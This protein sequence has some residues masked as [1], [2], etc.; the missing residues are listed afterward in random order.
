MF[1]PLFPFYPSPLR[2]SFYFYT[3][4][5]LFQFNADGATDMVYIASTSRIVYVALN[6][7]GGTLDAPSLILFS[8]S[9]AK[10]IAIEDIDAD[11]TMDLVMRVDNEIFF[12]TNDGTGAFTYAILTVDALDSSDALVPVLLFD[13]NLDGKLDVVYS[14]ASEGVKVAVQVASGE[15]W[16]FDF[17]EEPLLHLP[18]A[19]RPGLVLS[20]ATDATSRRRCCCTPCPLWTSAH[21]QR[22]A[23]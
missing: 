14:Y 5:T 1:G 22:L 3:S 10:F 13:V 8:G 9:V 20:G 12:Y 6:G 11:G 21:Q 18:D 15:D 23:F 2:R 16:G 7:N 17:E 19:I 4:S